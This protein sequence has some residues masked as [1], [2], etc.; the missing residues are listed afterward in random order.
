MLQCQSF[1]LQFAFLEHLEP[2]P[3]GRQHLETNTAQSKIKGNASCEFIRHAL[4][5]GSQ[6]GRRAF[7]H[8]R[9]DIARAVTSSDTSN[10]LSHVKYF[11]YIADA[12]APCHSCR[13]FVKNIWGSNQHSRHLQGCSE[14]SWS[15]RFLG[16]T[17]HL[18]GS[19]FGDSEYRRSGAPKTGRPASMST[20]GQAI[21]WLLSGVITP[22]VP[23]AQFY[24]TF[25]AAKKIPT[26]NSC[27][28]P[29]KWHL[30]PRRTGRI[31]SGWTFIK[32]TQIYKT[33]QKILVP[34]CRSWI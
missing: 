15:S 30:V 18:L 17:G 7:H 28:T 10:S 3:P 22:L 26:N 13:S 4:L 11:A 14:E 34:L 2:S 29:V 19:Q 31:I 8:W 33:D 27:R 16:L 12:L 5:E 21:A 32:G 6:H 25:F 1:M 24:H 9:T 20:K 23:T